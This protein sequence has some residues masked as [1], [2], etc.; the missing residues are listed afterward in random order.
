MDPAPAG[1]RDD[2]NEGRRDPF[3][4]LL[5][6]KA[7]STGAETNRSGGGLAAT[8]I[9]NVV[10]TGITQSGSLMLAILESAGRQAFVARV[11]DRL[12]DGFVESID[13]FGVVL[14]QDVAAGDPVRVRKLLKRDEEGS[15]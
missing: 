6:R 10:V 15:H 11:N 14:V 13:R 9:S 3:V 5:L 7:G 1:A 4:S 8:A 2:A 12:L